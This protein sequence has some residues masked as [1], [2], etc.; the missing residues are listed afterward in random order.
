MNPIIKRVLGESVESKDSPLPVIE[1]T[2]PARFFRCPH[3]Q[4]E[5][6][7]KHDYVDESG[8]TRHRECGGAFKWPPFDWST[9]SPAWRALLQGRQ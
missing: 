8:Q 5:I 4:Q 9:V 7:E 6:H 3:C 1:D 2:R